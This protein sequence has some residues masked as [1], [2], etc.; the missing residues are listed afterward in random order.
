MKS[1]LSAALLTSTLCFPVL[2]AAADAEGRFAIKGGGAFDCA[3]Y[4]AETDKGEHNAFMFG[5]W[6]Y[7]YITG[8][9]QHMPDTFDLA[10]WETLDTLTGYLVGYCRANPR[11]SLAQAV[12]QL[13]QA[14]K[15]DRLVSASAPERVGRGD[16]QVI[17]YP[18]VVRRLQQKLLD[19]GHLSTQ[20]SGEFDKATSDALMVW[21]RANGLEPSGVPDQQ[22]LH[23]MFRK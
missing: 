19:A 9:N 20:P 16:R 7:G 13:V 10:P 4:V 1:F 17:I 22:S 12:F 6:V 15:D 23:A 14:M 8:S 2:L 5:G 21:Q 3:T 18:E 11:A